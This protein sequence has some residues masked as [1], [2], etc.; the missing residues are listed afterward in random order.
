M[1]VTDDNR[2][3]QHIH[4]TGDSKTKQ[5]LPPAANLNPGGYEA[6]RQFTIFNHFF[7]F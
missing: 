7:K 5:K 4:I 2:G 3:L 6:R 1:T